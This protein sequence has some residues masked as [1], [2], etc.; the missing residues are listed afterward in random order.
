[1]WSRM[2]VDLGMLRASLVVDGVRNLVQQCR[3]FRV[4]FRVHNVGENL[5]VLFM[6]HDLPHLPKH[7][8]LWFA[9][10]RTCC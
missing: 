3:C 4:V 6:R 1:M 7:V 9:G 10:G 2:S 8:G 5:A